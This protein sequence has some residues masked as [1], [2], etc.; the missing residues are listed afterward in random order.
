MKHFGLQEAVDVLGSE[1]FR[2]AQKV[3][4]NNRV[5]SDGTNRGAWIVA[6]GFLLNRNGR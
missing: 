1:G 3:N 4:A 6:G 5:F 2:R